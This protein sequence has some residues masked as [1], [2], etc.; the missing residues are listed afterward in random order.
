MTSAE[1][2]EH[3]ELHVAV[4]LA[5]RVGAVVEH[6]HVDAGRQFQLEL[7]HQRLDR[8]GDGDGVGAR[9]PLDAERDGALL[10]VLGVE[11]RGGALVLDAV[12]DVAQLAQPHRRAVAVGDDHVLVL[13]GGHQLTGG[14]QREG[15]V[16]S[17]DRAGRHVDVPVAQ[18]RFDFVDADLPRRERVRIE[19]RVHGV[20][21]AAEHLHLRD[22]ADHRDALGDARLGVLVERPRRNRGRGDDEIENRL[23]GRVHLREGRRRRHA[24]RQQARRLRDRALHVDGGAVEA[25]VQVELERDL[26]RAERVDRGHRLEA[27]DHRELVLE[28]RRDRRAHRL[29]TGA[30][31]LRRDQQR[32]EVDVGQVADR[33]RAIRDQ[34]EQRDRRHQ[35]AGGDRPLDESFR[36]VQ[37]RASGISDFRFQIRKTSSFELQTSNF[38][39]LTS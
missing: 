11:P 16:R 15:L 34:A 26:R 1:R 35:Q 10:A 31:Q 3:G 30:G 28:R 22:A 33:Q 32:R 36:N 5:N 19:L 14:L 23:I 20:F 4:R 27:G 38:T 2:Q 21:L 37:D 18:R 8:V 24:L 25:A 9:L 13:V 7:R 39:L 17:D 29:G 12:D 6:V